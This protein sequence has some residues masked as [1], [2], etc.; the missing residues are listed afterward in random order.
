MQ[1]T[2]TGYTQIM[3]T[4]DDAGQIQADVWSVGGDEERVAWS[5]GVADM[6]EA[7]RYAVE[8]AD[9]KGFEFRPTI[10]IN[11]SV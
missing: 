9:A 6:G 4:K 10:L 8:L 5:T 7:V 3:L 1:T 2:T 11:Y